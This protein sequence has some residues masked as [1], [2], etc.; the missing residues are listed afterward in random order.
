MTDQRPATSSATTTSSASDGSTSPSPT[1]ASSATPGT[2]SGSA[3]APAPAGR[4]ASAGNAGP[5]A[6]DHGS[7]ARLLTDRVRLTPDR[8]IL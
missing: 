7:A 8:P 3:A 4:H 1:S 6:P 2:G 5:V